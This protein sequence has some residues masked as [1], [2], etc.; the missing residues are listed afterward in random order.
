VASAT[1]L[2]S[3]AC[4]TPIS[5][6]TAGVTRKSFPTVRLWRKARSKGS[7]R[8]FAEVRP[9]KLRPY[10]RRP[11]SSATDCVLQSGH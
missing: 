11:T 10:D 7:V 8:E 4:I 1:E 5:S 3:K 6:H 9:C 2:D